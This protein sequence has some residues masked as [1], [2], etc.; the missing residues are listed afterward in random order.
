[1]GRVVFTLMGQKLNI[2]TIW[3]LVIS[4]STPIAGVI[5]FAIQLRQVR[6]TRLENEKL[7]LEIESL[8]K[9]RADSERRIVIPTT[10]EVNRILT[11][12]FRLTEDVKMRSSS[13]R[14]TTHLFDIAVVTIITIV[15]SYATYDFYRLIVWIIS[16]FS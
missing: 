13:T 9:V 11:E 7:Q 12:D 10:N 3:L 6:K 4:L 15:V 16:L 14:R 2:Q 8:R 1:M 5:G